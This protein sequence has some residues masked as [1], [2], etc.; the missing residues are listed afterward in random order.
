[1]KQFSFL[2]LFFF[3]FLVSASCIFSATI[4]GPIEYHRT[5]GPPNIYDTT[6][7]AYDTTVIC[8]L[9]VVNGDEF[10]DHRLS[11]AS[12]EFNGEE[13][14]SESDFNTHVDTLSRV[15]SLRSEN[16]IHL[17]LRSGPGDY[18][19]LSILRPCDAFISLSV[20]TV[21]GDSACFSVSAG[22]WGPLTF[23]W[24]FTNDNIFDTTIT[25][26]EICHTYFEAD[27][28]RAIVKAE[29]D[30][31]CVEVDSGEVVIEILT[32]IVTQ[33]TLN[34][35]KINSPHPITVFGGMPGLSHTAKFWSSWRQY[36][37][38]S[39]Y[40]GNSITLYNGNYISDF[41]NM[42][43]RKSS[44]NEQFAVFVVMKD[45]VKCWFRYPYYCLIDSIGNILWFTDTSYNRFDRYDK[46]QI[47][48]SNDD[49]LVVF[50]DG[51]VG[52]YGDIDIPNPFIYE[53]EPDNF[54]IHNVYT[55]ELLYEFTEFGCNKW[56]F[57]LYNGANKIF[58]F[59]DYDTLFGFD[60]YANC[61]LTMTP[62]I[63][64]PT[65]LLYFTTHPVFSIGPSNRIYI[66]AA[67][68]ATPFSR[69]PF[70]VYE[71]AFWRRTDN[72]YTKVQA[73][74]LDTENNIAWRRV[75]DS[76]KVTVFDFS[77]GGRYTIGYTQPECPQKQ[78][79]LWDNHTNEFLFK[80]DFPK[81]TTRINN[82]R[83]CRVYENLFT[84]HCIV[85]VKGDNN[86][87]EYY[88]EYGQ[89]IQFDTS[90]LY[91]VEWTVGETWRDK[92]KRGR[93][94]ILGLRW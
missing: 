31:G 55:G 34:T 26:T 61:I 59:L 73:V 24:D 89:P 75:T 22:G 50:Y 29:D 7:I 62:V 28:Y 15:V 58:Y 84:G 69:K 60:S 17:R 27:T 91:G 49:S 43:F 88:N 83:W 76:L 2:F 19:T 35:F 86:F 68:A 10:G 33:E 18:L 53:Q 82:S 80:M 13:V 70:S 45:T 54:R 52:G 1:M 79:A 51:I 41:P 37:S 39:E 72:P 40:C 4:F 90:R 93:L 32:Y 85:E 6:F 38:D 46:N 64:F 74:C 44:N 20:D 57:G 23:F 5:V 65:E 3:F 92:F 47:T 21:I 16:S 42:Y 77:K 67:Y 11:A 94:T 66:Y 48:F 81:D 30:V 78:I 25:E 36:P 87:L 9:L 12:I 8:T 56:G 14:I 63:N 71:S